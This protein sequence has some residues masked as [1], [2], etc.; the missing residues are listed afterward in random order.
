MEA[1]A[2]T[3]APGRSADLIAFA[4]QTSDPLNEILEQQCLPMKV[5]VDGLLHT[6]EAPAQL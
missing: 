1:T 5:W 3:I 6:G 2:G 4:V